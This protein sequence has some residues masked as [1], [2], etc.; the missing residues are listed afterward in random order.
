MTPSVPDLP[1]GNHFWVHPSD[2]VVRE[3]FSILFPPQPE[4]RKKIADSLVESGFDVSKPVIVWSRGRVLLDGHTRRDAAID[5]GVD[6]L[7]VY[8]D[9]VDEDAALAYAIACQRDRRN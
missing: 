6:V 5:V 4:L 1:Q 3:P 9:F 8:R 7:V 2:L